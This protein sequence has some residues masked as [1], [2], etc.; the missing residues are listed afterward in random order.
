[1]R[2][3]GSPLRYF[4]RLAWVSFTIALQLPVISIKNG[5]HP[6]PLDTIAL[7]LPLAAYEQLIESTTTCSRVIGA[8]H[9]PCAPIGAFGVLCEVSAPLVSDETS[10][11][12]RATA[13]SRFRVVDVTRGGGDEEAP[14]AVLQVEPW[15]D[16]EPEDDDQLRAA[17]GDRRNALLAKER[18]AHLTFQAT[19]QLLAWN[20]ADRVAPSA[21]L[22]TLPPAERAEIYDAVHRFSPVEQEQRAVEAPEEACALPLA[23][24]EEDA[25]AGHDGC[26][27]SGSDVCQLERAYLRASNAGAHPLSGT[28]TQG[29]EAYAC[30][31]GELYSFALS[32][33]HDLSAE[34]TQALLEGRSTAGRLANAERQL[35]A[36]RRWLASRLG[37]GEH[38]AELAGFAAKQTAARLEAALP[39]LCVGGWCL[40][41]ERRGE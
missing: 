22:A 30:S 25:E 10:C 20:G 32:R 38:P 18:R 23:M 36:T 7:K 31:R 27:I 14:L 15:R 41:G 24:H 13:F 21:T 11:T 8:M 1:M 17:T 4:L 26:S 2:A 9:A 40:F 16:G 34:D 35:G 3:G 29:L 6:L 37:L 39:R 33:L 5:L 12:V 28:D 19:E